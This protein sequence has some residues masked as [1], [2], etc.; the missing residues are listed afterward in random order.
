MLQSLQG[1]DP[2]EFLDI[3]TAHMSDNEIANLRK[4]LSAKV[5]EYLLL[6]LAKDLDEKQRE[7]I[8][9]ASNGDD[10]LSSFQHTIPN[11]DTRIQEELNKFKMSYINTYL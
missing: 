4:D 8:L 2:I 3:T 1:F 5:G 7:K 9:T 10:I 11:L 6:Q